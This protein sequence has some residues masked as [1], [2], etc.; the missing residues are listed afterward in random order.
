MS[1]LAGACCGASQPYQIICLAWYWNSLPFP[2]I[3]LF[4]RRVGADPVSVSPDAFPPPLPQNHRLRHLSS[5]P[6]TLNSSICWPAIKR[7]MPCR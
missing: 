1:Q 3:F 5:H 6:G 2:A 4:L 7:R